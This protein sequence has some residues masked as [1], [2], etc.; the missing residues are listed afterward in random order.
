M[1]SHY[2]CC[3]GGGDPSCCAT[4]KCWY[5]NGVSFFVNWT[6]RVESWICCYESDVNPGVYTKNQDQTITHSATV[7][8]TI[9]AGHECDDVLVNTSKAYT[10][11]FNP[12][13]LDCDGSISLSRSAVVNT[14]F[15]N[16]NVT[17]AYTDMGG[18][19]SYSGSVLGIPTPYCCAVTL[20]LVHTDTDDCPRNSSPLKPVYRVTLDV[21]ITTDSKCHRCGAFLRGWGEE[22]GGEGMRAAAVMAPGGERLLNERRAERALL[23]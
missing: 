2:R 1:S 17:V 22:E 16:G 8:P 7:T 5:E 19:G 11:S 6:M 18:F 20:N 23:N 13:G 9:S 3:C 10:A 4:K 15:S 14:T 12:T 21:T